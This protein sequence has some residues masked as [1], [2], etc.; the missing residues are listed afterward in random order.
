MMTG[1]LNRELGESDGGRPPYKW[2]ITDEVGDWIMS[3]ELFEG[4]F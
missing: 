2:Q 4:D 3:A 1:T